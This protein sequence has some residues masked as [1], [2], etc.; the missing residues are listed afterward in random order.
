MLH[1]SPYWASLVPLE[2]ITFYVRLFTHIRLSGAALESLVNNKPRHVSSDLGGE[3]PLSTLAQL[4]RPRARFRLIICI[5]IELTSSFS[6][7][8]SRASIG[9]S[10]RIRIQSLDNMGA[11]APSPEG[12]LI[13]QPQNRPP[14]YHFWASCEV[15][16]I[17]YEP[18]AT[19]GITTHAALWVRPITSDA[20][21]VPAYNQ[22]VPASSSRC[23]DVARIS[24]S[25]PISLAPALK[26]TDAGASSSCIVQLRLT[27]P[28][29]ILDKRNI[30]SK[31]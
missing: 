30:L 6:E 9:I 26:S 8:P 23:L 3:T 14:H 24:D 1:T 27:L 31:I 13:A 18:R 2:D 12:L 17:D 20:F 11:W 22:A 19:P 25:S 21:H 5:V 10:S 4:Q 29:F 16:T 28:D 7:A 15:H